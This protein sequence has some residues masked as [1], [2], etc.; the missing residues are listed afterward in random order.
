M[1]LTLNFKAD[2]IEFVPYETERLALEWWLD[3]VN[4]RWRALQTRLP[5]LPS[6][7]VLPVSLGLLVLFVVLVRCL[8]L[9]DSDNYYML[10]PDSYFFHWVA[11]GIMAGDPPPSGP[12]L[13]D[14]Y[15][16][17]SGLAYPLAY[18][19]KAISSLFNVSAAG[20]LDSVSKVIPLVLA[21]ISMFVVYYAGTKLV[22]RCVGLFSALAWGALFHSYF[23]GAAGYIDRDGLSTLL[24]MAGALIFYLSRGWNIS[25]GNK[26]VA[27][28]L[29]GAAVLAIEGTLF[30]EWSFVGSGLLLA[31]LG[32]YV[33]VRF[34]MGY[35]SRLQAEP[36]LAR[37][38]SASLSEVNPRVL[39][40]VV[41]GNLGAVGL[42][43]IID[44]ELVV[45]SLQNAWNLFRFGGTG[46][47]LGG[48]AVSEMVGLNTGHV[49]AYR[50]LLIPM[51]AGIWLVWKRR[52]EGVVFVACW[53]L[54]LL[55]LALFSNRLLLY[56]SPAA[57]L[58]AGA[59]LGFFW[60]WG[61]LGSFS[62]AKKAAVGLLLTLI[63][64]FSIGAFTLGSAS[65]GF[66]APDREWQGALAFLR[67]STPEDAVVMAHWNYGY[68]ILDL[69]QRQPVVDNGYYFFSN[70]RNHD[71]GVAHAT[72]DPAEAAAI[73]GKYGADYLIFSTLD[74]KIAGAI[75]SE[76]NLGSQF[77]GMSEFPPDSLTRRTL[78]G[79]FESGG[80]LQVVYRS[81]PDSEVV[82]LGLA[83][84]DT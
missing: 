51:A 19:A 7:W 62:L 72:D 54:G 20:A 65:Y 37:R 16:L 1:S 80:G 43:A 83:G 34:L 25:I 47:A 9:L 41:L 30:I 26:N 29:G 11:R 17:H 49:L 69:S 14:T 59:G 56:A 6:R 23:I 35:S 58:L 78:D 21:V 45:S 33:L 3:K 28:L 74:L 77:E 55:A 36:S 79:E 52:Q 22:S 73:M 10:S 82:I 81:A 18:T 57:C 50:F 13:S 38:I 76:A 75:I 12:Y 27:W 2:R 68:W 15:W 71:I 31:I 61:K 5:H 24:I 70:E 44:S 32:T 53:F 46:K 8:H 39:A 64:L 67:E 63:V 66:M 42:A 60:E 84:S 40:V 4:Q 48:T